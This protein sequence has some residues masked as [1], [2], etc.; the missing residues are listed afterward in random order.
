[1]IGLSMPSALTTTAS[2]PL[3]GL[4]TSSAATIATT[5]PPIPPKM[6][7]KDLQQTLLKLRV[8][9]EQQ[10]KYF[11]DEL[12]DLNA[13]DIVLR[14][15][16][17]KV[18][19]LGQNIDELEQERERFVCELDIMSQQQTELDSLVTEMEKIMEL[20]PLD[21][22]QLAGQPS[23]GLRDTANAAP[24]D[25]Q[26]QNILQLQMTVNA[27][28][29]QLD[30]E[31]GDL[32]EQVGPW[33]G[34]GAAVKEQ[35]KKLRSV[36]FLV[37]ELSPAVSNEMLH[38][39]FCAFGDVERA[40]HIVD[41]KGKP[42]GEGIVEFERKVSAQEAI[43]QIRERVFLMTVN[44][45]PLY[46][47]FVEPRDEEDGLSE[48]MIQRTH[49][50]LKERELGPRFAS[51]NSFEYVYGRRWKDL[52]E[53]ER[54]RRA[55][56][57]AE[58]REQRRR[59]DADMEVEYE[60]YKAQLLREELQRR[61]EELER[62]EA[63]RQMRRQQMQQQQLM[64]AGM[65]LS[66]WEPQM[67]DGPLGRNMPPTF[68]QGAPM[69]RGMPGMHSHPP[70]LIGM[71]QSAHRGGG[72]GGG[73]GGDD[74]D[75]KPFPGLG[76]GGGGG[77]QQNGRGQSPQGP[78]VRKMLQG[79]RDSPQQQQQQQGRMQGPLPPGLASLLDRVPLQQQQQQQHH[80]LQQQQQHQQLVP[81]PFGAFFS[82]GIGT[83]ANG[84]GGG[85][86]PPPGGRIPPPPSSLMGGGGVPQ[87]MLQQQQ[88]PPVSL[89]SMG[90]GGGD[91]VPDNKK[92]R[93]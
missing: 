72:G 86:P 30:D 34:L 68:G 6:N 4:P 23:V 74:E 42:T 27:Q 18:F 44:S 2:A 1:M 62:L 81:S 47:E 46:A 82:S 77:M 49:H 32:C 53:F 66:G 71:G 39:A 89:M 60:D 51:M 33:D 85:G 61:Q 45:R 20:P 54:K 57:E 16:Q 76:S 80:H 14:R 37:K 13:F 35:K 70:S 88:Q 63:S 93:H 15:A 36:H 79:F 17:D 43:A 38:L 48:K 21:Q 12:D 87:H 55:E 84:G 73:G 11:M 22:Q 56:V 92:A 40:V 31:L 25:V 69:S 10:E 29:K 75:R 90:D 78:D 26:R 64:G 50:L 58:L 24:S 83:G 3:F 41:E 9:F 91:F 52:Y 28:M 5:A 19:L 8:D 7:F 67:V 59:L 65:M